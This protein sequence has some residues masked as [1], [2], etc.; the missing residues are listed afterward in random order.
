MK[1]QTATFNVEG[2]INIF[3]RSWFP[4]AEPE[5]VIII[6]HG[7]G[8]HSGRYKNVVN[9]LIP[10]NYAVF[11]FDWRGHG[12]S[13]GKRGHID[14]WQIL[15]N[16][17]SEFIKIVKGRLPVIP[18]F[19]FGHSM[20]GMMV[21]DYCMRYNPAIAGVI[22]TS[23]A[24]GEL[25][26]SPFLWAIARLLDK[27]L[28]GLVLPTGLDISKLSHDEDFVKQTGSDPLYHS[29]A[30]PRFGMEVKKTVAYIHENAAI[31]SIP[32]LLVHGTADEIV[33][34]EGSRNFA[35]KVNHTGFTYKEYPDGYHELFNDVMKDEVLA[36][37]QQW[38]KSVAK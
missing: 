29:K 25:A 4:V 26:I 37:I 19:L 18:L 35:G 24:I 33:S 2:D 11:A 16:D 17:L 12:L 30:T 27:I 36:D 5:A 15:R 23:P 21:L 7:G 10:F 8:D 13:P 31:F 22:C 9:Y 34:I 38:I 1:Q 3:Y 14:D 6:V 32:L 28:P 20:G